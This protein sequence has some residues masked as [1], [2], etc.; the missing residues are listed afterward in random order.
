MRSQ[1]MGREIQIAKAGLRSSARRINAW[2]AR[3]DELPVGPNPCRADCVPFIADCKRFDLANNCRTIDWR[4]TKP[5]TVPLGQQEMSS[6]PALPFIND[7]MGH[8]AA[9]GKKGDNLSNTP[10]V[11]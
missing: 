10:H 8:Q 11:V 3:A 7:P 6:G 4:I 9:A 2:E 1:L 5:V